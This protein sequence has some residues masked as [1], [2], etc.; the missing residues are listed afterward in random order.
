[1]KVLGV[2]IA[3]RD[4]RI[5]ALEKAEGIIVNYTGKYKPLKLEDD[6]RSEN[7]A[8]FKNTLFAIFE[9]Y[10]PDVIV[11]NYRDSSANGKY[12]AS[13]ISFKV[14]GL[15]QLYEKAKICF[16]KPQT[17]TA[18]YKKN[19]LELESDFAYQKDALKL[20]FHYLKTN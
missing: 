6:E 10:S 1:M 5:I 16:T 12:A 19:E 4:V 17:I 20:A 15:I 11:I 7:V 3:S 14:E 9:N 13:P 8:L 18:F 2:D